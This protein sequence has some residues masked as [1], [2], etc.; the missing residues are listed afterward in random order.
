NTPVQVLVYETLKAEL[1]VFAHVPLVFLNG[2]KMS[3]RDA[4][5]LRTPEVLAKLRSIGFS[6]QEIQERI[7][8][9]PIS[10]AFYREMGYLPAALVNYLGRLGWSLDEKSEIIPLDQM[11][12]HFSLERVN[13]AP[14][15]FDPQ[16]LLWLAGEYMRMLPLQERVQGVI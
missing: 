1:P 16:K 5:R 15:N 8:L 3:K 2:K 4:E 9:N 6:D 7:D 11:I 12:A 14:G 10:V 13:N